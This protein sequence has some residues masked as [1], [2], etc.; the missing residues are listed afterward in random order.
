M[1]LSYCHAEDL[2]GRV[3]RKL[4]QELG[5]LKKQRWDSVLVNQFLREVREAKKRGRKERR[6]REAQAVLAAAA[7]VAAASSRNPL[8]RK[9]G[10][11]ETGSTH[12]EVIP[13]LC[14]CGYIHVL[15]FVFSCVL[16]YVGMFMHLDA[17]FFPCLCGLCAN[18]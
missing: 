7:A 6:H 3:V 10:N 17:L 13:S 8:L 16:V 2:L 1:L 4:P 9:D 15:F 18:D 11:D 14:T 5:A 12:Q